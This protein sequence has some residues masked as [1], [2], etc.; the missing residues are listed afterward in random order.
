MDLLLKGKRALVTGGLSNLGRA[1]C[2]SLAKEGVDVVF[3]YSSIEKREKALIF[4]KSL[5]DTYDVSSEILFINL[6][7]TKDLTHV[8]QQFLKNTSLDILINNAGIF[9]ESAQRD[10]KE[11]D[12]DRVMNVNVKGIWR[13]VAATQSYLQKSRGVIVNISSMNAHRPGFGHTAHYD[14]SKG[15][16]SAYTRSLAKELSEWGIRVNA[17]APGLIKSEG[18]LEYAP[19]LAASY[20]SR[21]ALHSLVDPYDIAHIVSFLASPLSFAMTGEIVAAECGYGMM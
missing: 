19:S 8:L 20:I 10:L 4:A 21:S 15:A 5:S 7:E 12:W 3:S 14:A 13:M 18:L 2:T 17:V 1:I 11:E 6:H 16:V 9:T